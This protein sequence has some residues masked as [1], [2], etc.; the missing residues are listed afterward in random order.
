MI[1]NQASV[2]VCLFLHTISKYCES[3]GKNVV[4]IEEWPLRSMFHPLVVTIV[5][6]FSPNL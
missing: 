3:V 5:P 2:L 6:D 4:E 1:N